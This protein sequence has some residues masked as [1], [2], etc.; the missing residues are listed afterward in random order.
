[1]VK[2]DKVPSASPNTPILHFSITPI[3]FFKMTGVAI[4]KG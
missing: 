1:M 4:R 2:K 3:F